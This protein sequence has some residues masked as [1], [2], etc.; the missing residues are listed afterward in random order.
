[1]RVLYHHRTQGGWVES[2]HIQGIVEG[3]RAMGHQVEIVGPPGVSAPPAGA[4]PL[5]PA[6]G[7]G[8]TAQAARALRAA[9]R[10][11]PQGGFELLELSY[12]FAGYAGLLK[13]AQETKA[14]VIYE[15]AA[16]YACIGA[17]VSRR[18]GIP[19]VVE[20]NDVAGQA[21]LRRQR[22]ARLARQL[23]AR[24]LRTA[25]AVITITSYLSDELRRRGVE[26][27][28]LT[29]VP[30]GVDPAR[31]HLG[32]DGSPVRRRYGVRPEECLVGFCGAISP[33]YRL[34]EVAQA[35]VDRFAATPHMRLLLIGDGPEREAL[36]RKIGELG[37][38]DQILLGPRV[39]HQEVPEHLAAFDVALIPHCNQHGSPV[40]LFEYLGMA[41]PVV[42][43]RT[44]G[45]TD[46]VSHGQQALLA[47]PGDLGSVMRHVARLAVDREAA[48]AMGSRGRE[49]VLT[50]YTWQRNAERTAAVLE[51]VLPSR[52]PILCPRR[53]PDSVHE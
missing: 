36:R 29:I 39:S 27:R 47:E 33:W 18:T 20:F 45:V 41:K 1:M 52:V 7:G 10:R 14:D 12:N 3:L 5:T 38:S 34:P 16:A 32:I 4:K 19:L 50:R 25:S 21:G 49:L 17:M 11:L 35:F 42:A 43:V 22:F 24:V 30:N 8:S 40:K 44:A 46:I 13:A 31:F 28:R 48:A 23:E 6:A 9:A 53:T 2:V 37:C 51:S 26:E 15:R